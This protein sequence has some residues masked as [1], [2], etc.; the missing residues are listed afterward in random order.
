MAK[1]LAPHVLRFLNRK[2]TEEGHERGLEAVEQLLD[3]D[4]IDEKKLVRICQ[5]VIARST[6]KGMAGQEGPYK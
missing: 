3:V 1:T 5:K 2:R 6:K 4:K